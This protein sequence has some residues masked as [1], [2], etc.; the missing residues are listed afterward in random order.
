MSTSFVFNRK[1]NDV[2]IAN[3]LESDVLLFCSWPAV[4][5]RIFVRT[6]NCY[7]SFSFIINL[8]RYEDIYEFFGELMYVQVMKFVLMK[9]D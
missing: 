4:V 8:T 1:Q 9:E 5:I 2:A 6:T 3:C 7:I